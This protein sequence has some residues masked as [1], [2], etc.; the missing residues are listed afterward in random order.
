MHKIF[1]S[2]AGIIL[3]LQSNVTV[4]DNLAKNTVDSFEQLFGVTEGKRRNHTKGFC[5]SGT[6]KPVNSD[7][8]D[9]S[10]SS[11]FA[12]NSKVIGRLSHKG[13]DSQASDD[14][15]AEYGMGLSIITP[16]GERHLMSMN[17]LDFFPVATPEAFGELMQAKVK[18]GDAVKVFKQKN[19]DLQRFKAHVAKKDKTLKPYE[20]NTY[21]SLNSFYIVNHKNQKTAIRWSFVPAQESRLVVTP[22]QNFFFENL[23]KNLQSGE[24]AWDMV[25]TIANPGDAIDNAAL[26]WT[27][28]HRKILAA[29]LKISSVSSEK[30]GEC[31][32]INFDPMVL[33]KG[34]EPSNDPLL[35]ARRESYAISFGKRLS[36]KSKSSY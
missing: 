21:N 14:K 8:Q 1:I 7:I 36:E 20:G 31:D 32:Q 35:Q 16:T 17:T 6:L 22:G 11:M 18:G 15:Y 3:L 29:Q 12:G 34:F 26:P 27:G 9:F 33:S 30:Q 5:F 10:S 28:N 13:G 19:K 24:V 23:E 4:A 25:I 2:L